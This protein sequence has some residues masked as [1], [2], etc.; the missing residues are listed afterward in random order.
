MNPIIPKK[1]N[2]YYQIDLIDIS[3]FYMQNREYKWIFTILDLFTKKVYAFALKNKK[4]A[5][6]AE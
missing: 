6:I 2:L 3:K 5:T 1:L 4:E